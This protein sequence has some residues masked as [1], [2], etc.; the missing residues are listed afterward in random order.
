MTPK[1]KKKSVTFSKFTI[2]NNSQ[3]KKN[4]QTKKHFIRLACS[5]SYLTQRLKPIVK[6]L[7]QRLNVKKDWAG[8]GEVAHW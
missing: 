1:K 2:N 3:S 7:I 8:E 6:L 5:N 4:K